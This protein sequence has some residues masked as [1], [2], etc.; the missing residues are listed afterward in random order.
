VGALSREYL[1]MSSAL[2][3]NVSLGG[4]GVGRFP[5][6]FPAGLS[7]RCRFGEEVEVAGAVVHGGGALSCEH[8]GMAMSNGEPMREAQVDVAFGDGGW[9]NSGQTVIFFDVNLPPHL[10]WSAEPL[11]VRLG[12]VVA[13]PSARVTDAD[14]VGDLTN[15]SLSLTV[16]VEYGTLLFEEGTSRNLTLVRTLDGLNAVLGGQMQYQAPLPPFYERRD[17]ISISVDDLGVAGL[18]GKQTHNVSIEVTLLRTNPWPALAKTSIASAGWLHVFEL[19][20]ILQRVDVLASNDSLP[21]EEWCTLDP[22][23]L[24]IE[25]YP[26]VVYI[27]NISVIDLNNVY[28]A[29][30]AIFKVNV[31]TFS[32]NGIVGIRDVSGLVVLDGEVQDGALLSHHVTRNPKPKP[33]IG[34]HRLQTLHSK[35][36]TL[37]SKS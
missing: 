27:S 32:G 14:H 25:P 36:S 37:N 1:A 19:E 20:G 29:D 2:P 8:P 34:K 4:C 24:G 26:C 17:S 11:L 9:T 10:A 22:F 7:A 3:L 15:L 21:S 35:P 30:P 31:S 18:G 12:E 5:C 13:L 33:E 16:V 28:T 6:R 23:V